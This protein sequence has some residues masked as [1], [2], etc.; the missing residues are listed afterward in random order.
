MGFFSHIGVGELTLGIILEKN[1]AVV[2]S[3]NQMILWLRF[4]LTPEGIGLK[5]M[6]LEIQRLAGR[7]RQPLPM[8]NY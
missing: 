5:G 7:N 3:Q 2:G 1:H 6:Q 4:L 8:L